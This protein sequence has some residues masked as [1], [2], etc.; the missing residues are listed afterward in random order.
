[1]I[2]KY[3]KLGIIKNDMEIVTRDLENVLNVKFK[4]CESS[5]WGEYK[6]VN[7]SETER[8]KLVYNYIDDDWQEEE[9]KEYPLLLELNRLNDP[10]KVM[11]MLCDSHDYIKPLYLEEVEAKICTKKFY[12]RNGRFELVAKY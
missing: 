11:K 1:M 4:V 7:L 10:E 6:I 9:F 3:M 2:N 5:Y 12:F 8:I